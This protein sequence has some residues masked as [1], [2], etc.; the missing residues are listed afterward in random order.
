M[1]LSL[2]RVE[3]ARELYHESRRRPMTRTEVGLWLLAKAEAKKTV[4]DGYPV[5]RGQVRLKLREFAEAVNRRGG[6]LIRLLRHPVNE[7]ALV[8]WG[9]KRL[10]G[11][12]LLFTVHNYKNLCRG[13][14]DG[15]GGS[16]PSPQIRSFAVELTRQLYPHNAT[17]R[18]IATTIKALQM[19]QRDGIPPGRQRPVMEWHFAN[20]DR[21]YCH[22]V[23]SAMGWREKFRRIEMMYNRQ[24]KAAEDQT[25]V[26]GD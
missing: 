2:D 22:V 24:R 23:V 9:W 12:G 5:G 17:K 1:R 26:L 21:E 8:Q 10:E 15:S 4:D 18:H 3:L 14:T 7:D 16:E 19:M 13:T 6:K 11:G 20:L 25:Y